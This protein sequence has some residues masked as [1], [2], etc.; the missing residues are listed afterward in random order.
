M[1]NILYYLISK[2]KGESFGIIFIDIYERLMS[3]GGKGGRGRW[4]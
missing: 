4:G 1:V 2:N 3:K